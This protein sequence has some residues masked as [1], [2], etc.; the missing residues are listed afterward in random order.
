MQTYL[1][2]GSGALWNDF[3]ENAHEAGAIPGISL[4]QP[5]EMEM[6]ETLDGSPD[7]LARVLL[8]KAVFQGTVLETRP[9]TGCRI[10]QPGANILLDGSR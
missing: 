5:E 9:V 3:D 6:L 10:K 1:T 8:V 7:L 4:I 2:N